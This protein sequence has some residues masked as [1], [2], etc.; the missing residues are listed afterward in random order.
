MS[1]AGYNPGGQPSDGLG[2]QNVGNLHAK[3]I[4]FGPNFRNGLPKTP[5]GSFGTMPVLYAP[6]FYSI[7]TLINTD[8]PEGPARLS[9][10]IFME[11]Q[12]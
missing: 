4:F 12:Q 10:T 7:D 2:W 1:S 5:F 11:L 6:A 8:P 9:G 3:K